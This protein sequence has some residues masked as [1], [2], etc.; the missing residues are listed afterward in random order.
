MRST[1]LS[2]SLLVATATLALIACDPKAPVET[3]DTGANVDDAIAVHAADAGTHQNLALPAGNLVGEITGGQVQDGTITGNDIGSGAIAGSHLA[4]GAVG[5]Q[6]LAAN[7][8]D[9]GALADL[10]VTTAKLANTSV[11][12]TKLADDA[13][14]T[15]KILNG[16]VTGAKIGMDTITDANIADNAITNAEM[17][18]N[19]VA[20]AELADNAVDTNEL[21]AN[22]VTSAKIADGT[23]AAADIATATITDAQLDNILSG[24][25]TDNAAY[26]TFF[27]F[28]TNNMP[29]ASMTITLLCGAE[30][31][32]DGNVRLT[33]NNT[34]VAI[35]TC[36]GNLAAT[37]RIVTMT[38]T[39]V[40]NR[41]YRL[42][43][44]AGAANSAVV[45][46]GLSIGP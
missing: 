4:A 18:D 24:R 31:A 36:P 41:T 28:T 26:Q 35:V 9:T 6:A 19:A 7:A 23:I 38:H 37:P 12:A 40:N 15:A 20:N 32:T 39:P 11:D 5:S 42:E 2:Q 46:R 16:Q 13:V 14:T 30:N 1:H 27:T 22:A 33:E 17:A 29:P 8:V 45:W 3:S 43:A 21:A 44:K 10:S 25:E 34:E